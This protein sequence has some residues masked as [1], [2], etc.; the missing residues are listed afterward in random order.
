MIKEF[1]LF[2]VVQW[3]FSVHKLWKAKVKILE[4]L[5]E[6]DNN[7]GNIVHMKENFYFSFSK[8]RIH[9]LFTFFIL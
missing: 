7:K 9:I 2:S 6:Q 8:L 4:A 5:R 3:F 1:I